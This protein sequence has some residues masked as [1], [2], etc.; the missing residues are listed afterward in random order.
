MSNEP[1]SAL[2]NGSTGTIIPANQVDS[3]PPH[4]FQLGATTHLSVPGQGLSNIG[5]TQGVC[6]KC[7]ELA[8]WE[9]PT[10]DNVHGMD[11]HIL[12][13]MANKE[14]LEYGSED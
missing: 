8:D 9:A 3:C 5:Q 12:A 4:H 11:S 2:P 1:S 14:G 13:E 7:G 6:I 10:P